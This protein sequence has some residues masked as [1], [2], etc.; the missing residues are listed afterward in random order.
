MRLSFVVPAYNEEA[1]IR[2]CVT[3]IQAEIAR[4]AADAEIIVVN[5]ASTDRTGEVARSIPGVLVVD[6]PRKGLT[7]ARQSGFEASH[8]ELI[9]GIDADT[10]MPEGWISR[11]LAL[12]ERHPRMLGLS[13]PYIY[14]DLPAL[15]RLTM[16]AF[17][18]IGYAFYVIGKLF[19]GG[20]MACGGNLIVRR[21][22]LQRIGGYD[23][24]ITFYGEDVDL[25]RRLSEIGE[26]RW[27]YHLAINASG[28]RLAEEGL[29]KMLVRYMLNYFSVVLTGKPHTVEYT[30]VRGKLPSIADK[31]LGYGK[32]SYQYARAMIGR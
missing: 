19:G 29:G 8:G 15:P 22:A 1:R 4:T 27:S 6:E 13:G 14:Y 12:F 7:R 9:A 18:A 2:Q 30:D 11:A 28:R 26:T 31:V 16:R 23:T 24:S 3:A 32:R 21:D 10:L 20:I 25:M 17:D 5:N